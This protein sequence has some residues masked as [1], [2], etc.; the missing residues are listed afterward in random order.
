MVMPLS[1]DNSSVDDQLRETLV[2]LLER[3]RS[4]IERGR[5]DE[6]AALTQ[7]CDEL[8]AELIARDAQ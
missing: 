2:L 7:R 8:A 4:A 6:A 1:D 5:A 3:K